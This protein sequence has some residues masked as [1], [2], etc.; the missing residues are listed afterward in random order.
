MILIMIVLISKTRFDA[1]SNSI[2]HVF[3]TFCL[4]SKTLK[5]DLRIAAIWA[6]YHMI[7]YDSNQRLIKT[8]DKTSKN[9]QL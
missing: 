5:I 7:W 6:W 9:T 8:R 4:W 3:A 1:R 2:Y